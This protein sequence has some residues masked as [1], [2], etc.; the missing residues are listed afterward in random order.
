MIKIAIGGLMHESNTFAASRTDLAG[1]EA[2]GLETGPS[3]ATRWGEAH[4]EVGGFFEGARVF[5][6]EAVP[7]LM[8]WATPAGPVTAEA[9]RELTDRLIEAAATTSTVSASSPSET[10]SVDSPTGP[11][12]NRRISASS[13][14]R[15]RRSR[16]CSSTS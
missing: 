3:I 5:G 2:G 13:T 9:Y 4:H 6:F 1:F 15:S 11:P 12:P 14:P 10:A 8:A 7:T 16:P